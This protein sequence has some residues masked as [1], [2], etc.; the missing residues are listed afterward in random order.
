MNKAQIVTAEEAQGSVVKDKC[1][2][3]NSS[4]EGQLAQAAP[5]AQ[6][7]SSD[8]A[9]DSQISPSLSPQQILLKLKSNSSF[10]NDF[11]HEKNYSSSEM[12]FSA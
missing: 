1:M 8:K 4:E 11:P 6:K 12:K 2:Q 5:L 3:K 7:L 10:V 9:T